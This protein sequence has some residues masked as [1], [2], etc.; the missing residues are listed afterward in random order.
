MIL[1]VFRTLI[2]F[3]KG[4]IDGVSDRI[5]RFSKHSHVKTIIIRIDHRRL[6]TCARI[7]KQWSIQ[8][9]SRFEETD[10]AVR[11]L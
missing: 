2:D 8:P 11:S 5:V 7:E 1:G 3:I 10:V 6:H 4:F 9:H